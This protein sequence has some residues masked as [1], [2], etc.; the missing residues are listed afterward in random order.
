MQAKGSKT[1]TKD[2]YNRAYTFGHDWAGGV[3]LAETATG[4][5]VYF[6]AGD[7]ANHINDYFDRLVG[8]CGYS[9]QGALAMLWGD[10]GH[11]A[12][13]DA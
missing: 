13:I 11:L 9:G 12:S 7:D 10:Y 2:P 3:T 4:L 8:D 6:Q 5:S 1:M